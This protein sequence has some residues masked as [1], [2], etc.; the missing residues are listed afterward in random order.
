LEL[1]WCTVFWIHLPFEA[2]AS[3]YNACE[4]K[5]TL[6]EKGN[7]RIIGTI[8]SR[9][10]NSVDAPCLWSMDINTIATPFQSELA[11]MLHV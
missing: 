3:V 9:T 2:L 7:G 4:S 5:L 10:I 6:G 1:L 8:N 11:L